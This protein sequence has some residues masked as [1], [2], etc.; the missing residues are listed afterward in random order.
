MRDAID[1]S[2]RKK[3]NYRY[4]TR[5]LYCVECP[6]YS[7]RLKALGYLRNCLSG[8]VQRWQLVKVI[9]HKAHHRRWRMVQCYS[10]GYS[11]ASSHEGTLVPPG[12]YNW[13]CASFG[14]D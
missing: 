2:K 14:Y 1:R 7:T 5:R 13:I 3:I 4:W 9:W 12:E 10:T 8:R 11:N 6:Q